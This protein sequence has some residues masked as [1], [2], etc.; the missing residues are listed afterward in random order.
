M[1]IISVYAAFLLE[2]QCDSV[3]ETFQTMN[4]VAGEVVLVE[5]VQVEISQFVVGNL[6][7]K[8]VIDC[9]QDFVGDGHRGRLYPRRALRR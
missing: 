2:C 6:P 8:H 9:H 7:G 3:T 5:F 1:K 4:E